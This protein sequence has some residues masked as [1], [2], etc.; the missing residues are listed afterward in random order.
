MVLPLVGCNLQAHKAQKL[1]LSLV[2]RFGSWMAQGFCLLGTSLIWN[3]AERG[4]VPGRGRDI[5]TCLF[6]AA[7][8]PGSLRGLYHSTLALWPFIVHEKNAIPARQVRG[9]PTYHICRK[10]LLNVLHDTGLGG[11]DLEG[12]RHGS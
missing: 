3:T 6:S 8:H 2:Q 7:V 9:E 4:A 12:R 10:P 1:I 11:R 5:A